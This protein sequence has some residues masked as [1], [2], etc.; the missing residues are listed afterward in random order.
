MGYLKKKMKESNTIIQEGCVKLIVI[1]SDSKVIYN[2]TKD[3]HYLNKCCSF[4][5]TIH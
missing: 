5:P 4:K 3:L 1:V 2:V